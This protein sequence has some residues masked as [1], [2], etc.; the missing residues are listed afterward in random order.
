MAH[1]KNLYNETENEKKNKVKE[2][3]VYTMPLDEFISEHKDL[4]KVLRE[5]TR[6]ELLAMAKQQEEE[7]EECLEEHGMSEED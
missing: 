5:G 3:E 6:D 2:K 1:L 4:I 7:L